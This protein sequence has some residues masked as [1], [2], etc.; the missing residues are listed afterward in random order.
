MTNLAATD[1]ASVR[2]AK[3]DRITSRFGAR[4]AVTLA[5]GYKVT[6]LGRLAKG[7]AVRCA[8]R[9]RASGCTSEAVS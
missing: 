7:D 8:L 6:L 3:I 2:A 1:Y 9:L 5:D 4:T